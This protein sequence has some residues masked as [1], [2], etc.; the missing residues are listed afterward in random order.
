MAKEAH[1]VFN[2][3]DHGEYFDIAVAAM[4]LNYKIP[5]IM[6]GTVQTSLTVDYFTGQGKPCYLCSDD[7]ANDK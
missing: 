7:A 6:G 3:I 2:C 5:L 4:C 1:V